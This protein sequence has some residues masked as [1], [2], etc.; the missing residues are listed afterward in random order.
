MT[1]LHRNQGKNESVI[2]RSNMVG[3]ASSENLNYPLNSI[4]KFT[5]LMIFSSQAISVIMVTRGLNMTI[6]RPK[7]H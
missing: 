3:I 7:A 4:M 5:W 6:K 2:I 1:C